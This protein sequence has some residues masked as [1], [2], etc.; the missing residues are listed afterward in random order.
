MTDAHPAALDEDADT[1]AQAARRAR[2]ADRLRS[3]IAG[4]RVAT[5]GMDVERLLFVLGAV[6]LPL[7]LLLVGVA[8][9]G[10]ANT[11]AVF[12]QIPFLVSGGLGGLALVVVGGVLYGAWWQ[13]RALR[14][15]RERAARSL[16]VAE[17]TLAAVQDLAAAQRALAAELARAA[18]EARPA[19]R[20]RAAA[21]A[22]TKRQP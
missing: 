13:T 6:L 1:D 12:E 20:R 18:A 3:T 7:G 21:S 19:P 8:W 4:A 17:A 16:E 15:E 9:R 5:R 11:G 22:G 10:T 14:E 2:R